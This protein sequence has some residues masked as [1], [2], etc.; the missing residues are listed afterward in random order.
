MWFFRFFW[1]EIFFGIFFW[2]FE[3]QKNSRW[4]KNKKLFSIVWKIHKY[5]E[6]TY[7]LSIRVVHL[8]TSKK[9]LTTQCHSM[10]QALHRMNK[11]IPSPHM[12]VVSYIHDPGKLLIGISR[13]LNVSCKLKLHRVF[14]TSVAGEGK[15]INCETVRVH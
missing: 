8:V 2:N 9:N 13:V 5:G 6:L 1:A 4:K 15:N 7:N 14:L 11:P 12:M 10:F 3:N